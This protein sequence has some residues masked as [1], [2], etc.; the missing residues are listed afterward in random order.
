MRPSLKHV[1]AIALA[2]G[3]AACANPKGGDITGSLPDDYR[4]RHPVVVTAGAET[5]DLLPG[6]GPGGLTDR[7][8]GD[9]QSFAAKWREKGRGPITVEVPTG[10]A[11]D[12][13]SGHAAKEI[14]RILAAMGIAKK[15]TFVRTYPADGPDHLAPVRLGY[16]ALKAKVPHACDQWPEDL[17]YGDPTSSN[18]NQSY[19]NFG[20][21]TQQNTAAMVEDPEDFIRPRAED[22]PSATRRNDV[23][24]KYSKGQPT[25][26]S[27]EVA[28]EG[29]RE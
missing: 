6:G 4:D 12:R 17:G 1:A 18:R 24:T 10:G 27:G 15:S 5:M 9:V 2:A 25:A 11:S 21:A 7:Q 26:T 19:W 23:L 29:T 14:R 3:L 13:A 22:P 16:Q 28:V 20:C 8:V